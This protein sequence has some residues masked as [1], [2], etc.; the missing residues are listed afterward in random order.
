M[1]FLYVLNPQT[2]YQ[3]YAHDILYSTGNSITTNGKSRADYESEGYQIMEEPEYMQM[4]NAYLDSLCNQWKEITEEQYENAMNI[5][6]P[7]RWQNGGF[8]VPEALTGDV[9][10]FYQELNGKYYT[11]LQRVFYKREAIMENLRQFV[12]NA[13]AQ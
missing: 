10:D 9:Y 4:Q 1:A 11:S 12:R 2:E 6:P 3:G 13:E 7:A 5:L 8:F